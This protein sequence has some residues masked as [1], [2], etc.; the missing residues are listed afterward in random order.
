MP[1]RFQRHGP[2]LGGDAADGGAMDPEDAGD[3]GAGAASGEHRDNLGSLLRQELGEAA[4]A[5]SKSA[6]FHVRKIMSD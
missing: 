5:R 6:G 1:P 3:F 4:L 2:R